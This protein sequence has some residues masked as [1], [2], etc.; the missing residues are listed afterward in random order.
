V[1]GKF[2]NRD[3]FIVSL[4]DNFPLDVEKILEDVD[5][6]KAFH[7]VIF[8]RFR[9]PLLGSYNFHTASVKLRL[10]RLGYFR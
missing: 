5:V 2:I 9:S 6:L 4:G 1:F 8:G 7:P 3:K 10:L